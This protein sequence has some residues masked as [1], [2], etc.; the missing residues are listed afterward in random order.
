MGIFTIAAGLLAVTIGV[1]GF[2]ADAMFN[3][4]FISP[5]WAM[6]TNV[7]GVL[8][9]AAM[10]VVACGAT[11]WA[12][13]VGNYFA[14]LALGA[15]WI[16][17]TLFGLGATLDRVS[18]VKDERIQVNKSVNGSRYA[19]LDTIN[20]LKQQRDAE[21][22]TG[23][24]KRWKALNQMII[25][26]RQKLSKL[27]AQRVVDSSASRVEMMTA[28]LI[29]GATWRVFHP[30]SMG[31]GILLLA[32]G[33]VMFGSSLVTLGALTWY[34]SAPPK[35]PAREPIDITPHVDDEGL[36]SAEIIAFDKIRAMGKVSNRALA[37]LLNWS[38]AKTS[39]TVKRLA[40]KDLV[41]RPQDGQAKAIMLKE[42][43][44]A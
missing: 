8:V 34:A 24:G 26:E 25:A 21:A 4:E 20:D 30:I 12:L 38:E 15:G 9:L 35:A 33:F 27:G 41:I 1:A 3:V 17:G 10:T 28:G 42:A 16:F 5:T 37:N 29:S 36:E 6:N 2:T 11:G 18:S 44:A 32:N 19:A 13:R 14:A 40:D 31:L 22:K 43:I 23:R 39:R 7:V